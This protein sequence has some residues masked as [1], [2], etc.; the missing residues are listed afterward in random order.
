MIRHGLQWKDATR[1]YG[2]VKTL[3][4][5][6]AGA[7]SAWLRV[8]A[9]L[10]TVSDRPERLMIDATHLKAHHTAAS[11]LQ[12]LAVSVA[13]KGGLNSKLHAVCDGFGRPL[14]LLLALPAAR[15][16]LPPEA[17]TATAFVRH[18]SIAGL[19]LHSF[20]SQQESRTTLRQNTLP[21]AQTSRMAGPCRKPRYRTSISG[22]P[23][24]PV[25]GRV[26]PGK[27]CLKRSGS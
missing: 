2:P 7:V 18:S 19:P 23:E 9:R 25:V 12:K 16:C 15:K 14:L 26:Q 17:T 21:T 20:N 22:R 6:S 4:G 13:P 3:T 5:S 11:L 24:L 8:S 10:A 1:G 27:E